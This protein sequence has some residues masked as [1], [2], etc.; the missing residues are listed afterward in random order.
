MNISHIGIA[1]RNIE[2]ALLFFRLLGG[3]EEGE[4]TAYPE[5]G[6]NSQQVRIGDGSIELMEPLGETG[7]IAEFLRK[8]GEG[9]HHIALRAADLDRTAGYF[10]EMN[11]RCIG[12]EEGSGHFFIHPRDAHSILIEIH[13]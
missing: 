1:V 8:H 4:K 11:I 5:F 3:S 6:M 7:L 2:Q 13:G 10:R 12:P 9:V